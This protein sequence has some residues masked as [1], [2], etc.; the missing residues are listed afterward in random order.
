MNI[1]IIGTGGIGGY[2]GGKLTRLLQNH[3]DLKIYFIARGSHLQQIREHGLTLDT[4]EGEFLCT[5]TL[6]T[7]S[8]DDLP[9]LDLVLLCVKGFDLDAA[10]EKIKPRVHE[11][12][13]LL[14]LL[15]GVDIY[16][17]IRRVITDGVVFPACVYVGTHIERPGKVT[18]RGG[19]CMIHFGKDP[20]KS[21]I[22]Q[23]VF[24]LFTEAKIKYIF[25]V[26]PYPEI[27]KKY[28]FIAAFG[29]VTAASGATI[30]EVMRSEEL[31][32]QVKR[33]MNEIYLISEKR[34]IAL[35]PSIVEESYQKGGSF[36][37]ET[38]T[39]FQRDYERSDKP[40]ERELFASPIIRLG[41]EY[42]IATPATEE[43]FARLLPKAH[44]TT[45]PLT[46]EGL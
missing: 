32:A 8:F 38:K 18:Q 41:G 3:R 2:F 24:E 5:P 11:K 31:G 43:V 12:T 14:P 15:N 16:E 33:I 17:R 10:L 30:G 22:D 37:F 29:L 4:D 26:D 42:G 28:I 40:D 39:S 46:K 9:Q 36:P 1:A 13:M 20:A 34:G 19:A 35:S 44:S 6:A 45:M 21:Y 27:W 23:C 7:D 25:Y